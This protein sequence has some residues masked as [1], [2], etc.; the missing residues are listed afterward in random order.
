MAAAAAPL[1]GGR[2]DFSQ[3]YIKHG[4]KEFRIPPAADGGFA[5]AAD[6]LHIWPRAKYMLI[7]LPNPVARRSR[8]R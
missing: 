7:A 6:C 8:C 2:V 4:Y 3:A 1:T 5:L